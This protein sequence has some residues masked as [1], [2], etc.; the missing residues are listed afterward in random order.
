MAGNFLFATLLPGIL[1]GI[2]IWIWPR[3]WTD[4]LRNPQPG[5]CFRDCPDPHDHR[6]ENGRSGMEGSP[7]SAWPFM[8]IHRVGD[9]GWRNF[10]DLQRKRSQVCGSFYRK[11]LLRIPAVPGGRICGRD[12]VSRI[13]SGALGSCAWLAARVLV[14]IHCDE[15]FPR[16]HPDPRPTPVLSRCIP[17]SA[18]H[19]AFEPAA[20]VCFAQNRQY[21]AAGHHPF[22]AQPDPDLVTDRD[23]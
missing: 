12:F 19:A 23:T 8:A 10:P 7:V 18:A 14:G 2:L 15:L 17:G 16:P 1:S 4:R 9:S 22:M 6:H 3:M 21:H 13:Y 11:R 5:D 20:G